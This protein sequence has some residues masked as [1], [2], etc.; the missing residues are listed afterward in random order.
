MLFNNKT[1]HPYKLGPCCHNRIHN[2]KA[3]SR[4]LLIIQLFKDVYKA[5]TWKY[6][7]RV[8]GPNLKVHCQLL[9]TKII[10]GN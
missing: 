9:M 4:N 10:T 6:T 3:D 2:V 7:R 8:Q 1:K 5:L